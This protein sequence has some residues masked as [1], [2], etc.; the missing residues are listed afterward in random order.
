M[1][2]DPAASPVKKAWRVPDTMVILLGLAMLAWLSTFILIPGRFSLAGDPARIV[3]GSFEAASQVLPAPLLGDADRA[4]FLDFL[5]SGLVSGDRYSATVGLLAFILI[6]GGVFGM[7]MRT[8]A[9]DAALIAALPNGRARNERL[10]ITM[11]V[12]FSL[13]GA[14]FGMSEEAIAL[15]L[16]LTPALARAGYDPITSVLVCYVA[17]QIGFATSW[18]NPFSVVIAQSMSGL[19]PMSGMG[20]RIGIWSFFTLVGALFVWRHSRAARLAGAVTA[21]ARHADDD[22]EQV[23]AFSAAHV[24]I[25]AAV[26]AGIAW[27]AWGVVMQGY[28]LAEIAAQFFAVG[29]A[30]AVVANLSKLPC[31][32]LDELATA[33]RE[34]AAQLLPAALVV[35]AAKGI[36]LLLGGDDPASFSLL[37][38]LLQNAAI[39]TAAV[40][41]WLTAWCMFAA[42]SVVNMFIVSGSGQASVTMPLMAPLADLS[43]VT[44]QTA[45]L[46]FQLGDGF[47]NLIV[48]TSAALMGSLAAARV[49]YIDWL[50]FIRKP[51]LILFLMASAIMLAAQAGGYS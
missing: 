30:V 13:G 28:Y 35:A 24:I 50:R 42:Q 38:T 18:M 4:G 12:A 6:L 5:F 44:R 3:S 31:C 15:T 32:S 26:L 19:P 23:Q 25:L 43:G 11:F 7:I 16:V 45:V 20:V 36:I 29:L 39:A 40:P 27:V 21:S 8:R 51:M 34:G 48:P 2:G 46:A 47:M 22:A 10:V 14:V 37:N 9:I 33:F 49:D 41:D 1:Q 17:T